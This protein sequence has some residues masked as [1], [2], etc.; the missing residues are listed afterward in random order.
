MKGRYLHNHCYDS[1]SDTGAGIIYV[2]SY[3]RTMKETETP[4]V[5]ANKILSRRSSLTLNATSD[6]SIG[7]DTFEHI[8]QATQHHEALWTYYYLDENN[9]VRTK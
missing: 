9:K 1:G 4:H 2:H 5:L 6:V 3:F 8:L 7:E